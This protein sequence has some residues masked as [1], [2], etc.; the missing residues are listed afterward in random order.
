MHKKKK[1]PNDNKETCYAVL[2]TGKVN[3]AVVDV[4]YY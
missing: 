4:L 1:T 2:G 3:G